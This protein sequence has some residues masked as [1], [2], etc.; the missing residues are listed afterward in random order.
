MAVTASVTISPSTTQQV[1]LG[2]TKAF[3]A[4]VTNF[5]SN[6]N[7]NWSATAGS[8]SAASTLG[9][10]VASTTYTAPLTPQV[11]TVTAASAET[12]TS[13]ASVTLNVY[14]P[15]ALTVAVTPST[16]VLL[17]GGTQTF[18]ATVSGAPSQ[19]VTWSASGGSIG[20]G[21]A[22]TAPTLTLGT[23][24][25][26]VTATSAFAGPTNTGTATISVKSLDVNADSAVDLKDL[27]FIANAWGSATSAAKLSDGATVNDTDLQAF[28]ANF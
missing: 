19:A 7:A 16:K 4:T 22:F 27:A 25:I 14:T 21:G 8:F 12:P 28:L 10:G 18:A 9:N 20:S 6:Q 1:N 13:T 17:S 15:S 24:T 26:T 2:A 11:V 23:Q 3:T 5:T